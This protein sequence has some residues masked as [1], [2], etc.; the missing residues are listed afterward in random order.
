MS[1]T[2]IQQLKA[3]L[4]A[5]APIK[6]LWVGYSGG[7]DSHVLL[8]ALSELQSEYGFNLEAIHVNHGL[9]PQADMFAL[10]CQKV[11]ER[12]GIRYHL[13][14]VNIPQVAKKSLE[15]AARE[16]R[17]AAFKTKIQPDHYLVTA[18]HADDQAETFL[19]QLLRGA[20]TKGLSAMPT[21]STLGQG[22][23]WRPLLPLSRELLSTYAFIHRLEWIEDESNTSLQF[24][25]NYLRQ[26]VIPSLK[27]RWPHFSKSVCQS[28]EHCAEAEALIEEHTKQNYKNIAENRK[29]NLEKLRS[30]SKVERHHV[31]RHWL[32]KKGFPTPG[33]VHL[34][35]FE[36][37]FMQS[38]NDAEPQ[39]VWSCVQLRRYQNYLYALPKNYQTPPTERFVW[40]LQEPL[41]L[42]NNLGTLIAEAIEAR[43]IRCET[44]K[45]KQIIEVN[46][47]QGGELIQLAGNQHHHKLKKYWQK[48]KIPPWE[49]DRVPLLY[50]DGKLAQVLVGVENY[51]ADEFIAKKGEKGWVVRLYP[52]DFPN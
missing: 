1:S 48:W 39:L 19:L 28:A 46:F 17:Y 33:R 5:V 7:M 36:Q 43:G 47:R 52:P 27:K 38:R 51:I 6:T 35:Q 44:F 45:T 34:Q 26:Q 9:T 49:R 32:R 21:L 8:H 30:L 3:Q 31:L 25:R 23:L 29:L 50:I 15:E 40:H 14:T 37:Q 2:I 24:D 4:N 20:G 13:S 18:H 22:W 10:H 11:C 41:T 12:L 16:A 42:P